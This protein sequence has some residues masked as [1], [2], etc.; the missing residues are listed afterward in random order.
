MVLFMELGRRTGRKFLAKDPKHGREGLATIEAAV[1]GLMGLMIAF[2]FSGAAGRFD[3]RRT[4]I[5]LEANTIGT[6]WLRIDTLP[7]NHQPALRQLFRDYTDARLA[8]FGSIGDEKAVTQHLAEVAKLQSDIWALSIKACNESAS[9]IVMNL[10]LSALNQMF[11]MA[12]MRDATARIHPPSILFQVLII[13]MLKCSFLAGF[14]MSGGRIRNYPH[15]LGFAIILA[16]VLYVIL[17]LEDP[18]VGFIR[19]NKADRPMIEQR[20]SMN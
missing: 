18:R 10:T 8:V 14:G 2:T 9:P 13:L 20:N 17:D 12:T 1:F 5:A 11:D 3:V 15:I 16:A 6:A 4:Q 19:I 7:A